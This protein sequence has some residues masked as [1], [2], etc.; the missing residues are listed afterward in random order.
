LTHTATQS[1]R[2]FTTAIG[3]FLGSGDLVWKSKVA[4]T[5]KI[6][7]AIRETREN[8]K[9]PR[10][11]DD[12]HRYVFQRVLALALGDK[13]LQ[14]M[15]PRR[16]AMIGTGSAIVEMYVTK[17]RTLMRSEFLILGSP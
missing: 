10:C 5:K 8:A 17:Q 3:K 2:P 1:K 11:C 13:E 9:I 6:I 14:R 4:R 12:Q 7:I 16:F 15:G